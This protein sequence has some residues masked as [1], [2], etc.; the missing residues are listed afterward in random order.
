M[1]NLE[2]GRNGSGMIIW[3]GECDQDT[4]YVWSGKLT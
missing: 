2:E 3:G 4:F 1:R